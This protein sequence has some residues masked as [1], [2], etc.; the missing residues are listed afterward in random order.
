MKGILLMTLYKFRGLQNTISKKTN[1]AYNNVIRSMTLSEVR[2]VAGYE[3]SS[4]YGYAGRD[5]NYGNVWIQ[6]EDGVVGC[7]VKAGCNRTKC[8]YYGENSD[9]PSYSCVVK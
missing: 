6:I 1:K 3:R 8:S 7:I 5:Y 9:Y 2:E 4:S